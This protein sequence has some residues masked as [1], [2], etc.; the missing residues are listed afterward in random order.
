MP[1]PR[2]LQEAM[3]RPIIA[4]G[5]SVSLSL[6]LS[7]F[8]TRFLSLSLFMR[9]AA[10]TPSSFTLLLLFSPC[11][12]WVLSFRLQIKVCSSCSSNC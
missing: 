7:F 11:I 4:F 10:R 8:P 3:L 6:S 2:L 12:T 1:Q 9:F 5:G